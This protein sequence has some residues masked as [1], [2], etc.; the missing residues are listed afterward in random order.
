MSRLVSTCNISSKSM[1]AFLNNLANRQTDKRTRK[2]ICT[3]S[4]VGGK[5][6]RAKTCTSSF[7]P[8]QLSTHKIPSKSV[9]NFV[10][11]PAEILKSGVNRVPGSE[12]W[13]RSGSKPNQ[14][15]QTA[16]AIDAQNFIEIRPWLQISRWNAKIRC[17]SGSWI[18]TMIRI[19][20]QVKT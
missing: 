6:T 20:I 8:P 4:F 9:H 15:V 13:P 12:L 3:S 10:R 19:G 16:A 18:R 17:K 11:Y 1:R 5:K 2:K 14:I 7:V